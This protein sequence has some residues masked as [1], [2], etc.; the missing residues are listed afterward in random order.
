MSPEEESSDISNISGTSKITRSSIIFSPEIAPPKAVFRPVTVPK[1]TPVPII[2]SAS[3][4]VNKDDTTPAVI[5][6]NTPTTETRGK[7]I[8]EEPVRTKAQP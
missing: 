2:I 1:V 6:T 5:P 3:A 8:K 4:P 7:S